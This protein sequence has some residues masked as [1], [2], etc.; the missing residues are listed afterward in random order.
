VRE[1]ALRL[2]I[3]AGVNAYER[4]DRAAAAG[5]YRQGL[6]HAEAFLKAGETATGVREQALRLY[7]GAG[8]NAFH[9]G[10]I[11]GARRHE[12]FCQM[13]YWISNFTGEALSPP[14]HHHTLHTL[15]DTAIPPLWTSVIHAWLLNCHGSQVDHLANHELDTL[16]RTAEAALLLDQAE[17]NHRFRELFDGLRGFQE[18]TQTALDAHTAALHAAQQSLLDALQL[19]QLS[20]PATPNAEDCAAI[21]NALDRRPWWK[22]LLKSHYRRAWQALRYYRTQLA[23]PP[24][25]TNPQWRQIERGQRAL[26]D[27]LVERLRAAGRLPATL[28]DHTQ[29]ALAV[30]LAGQPDSPAATVARWR[31]QPPWGDPATLTATLDCTGWREWLPEPGDTPQLAVYAWTTRQP[32]QRRL[33]IE[34]K[35]LN[36]LDHKL[37][38]I[39]IAFRDHG[40]PEPLPTWLAAAWQ[41]AQPA[42]EAV[43]RLLQALAQH[44]QTDAP[45][46]LKAALQN[47]AAAAAPFAD[48]ALAAVVLGDVEAVLGQA[49]R[50]WLDR[51]L[52]LDQDDLAETLQ[53]LKQRFAHVLNADPGPPEATAL[54]QRL[55]DWSQAAL[56]RELAVPNPDPD[57]LW[58]HL[59]RGRIALTGLA[60]N[61]PDDEWK[62]TTAKELN[63][64]IRAHL[65]AD[66]RPGAAWPPLA[67]WLQRTAAA[68]PTAPDAAACQRRLKPAE[69]LAQLFFDPNS[70]QLQALWLTP[71]APLTRRAFPATAQADHWRGDAGIL[72]RWARWAEGGE[73]ETGFPDVFATFAASAPTRAL[74]ATLHSWAAETGCRHLVLLL[75]AELAQL[76]WEALDAFD[77]ERLTLE[78]PVH[79]AGWRGNDHP[80]PVTDPQAHIAW[81]ANI[82]YGP[83]EAAA[84]S[85]YWRSPAPQ[86]DDEA[87]AFD[88]MAGLHTRAHGHLTLHGRYDPLDP[89]AS[90]L[91][92]S[93]TERI[94]AWTL[95]ALNP[96]GHIALSA[97]QAGLHGRPAHERRWLGSVG[98]GPALLAAGARRVIAPLW[99]C[100][101]VATWLFHELLYEAAA[102][103]PGA[104]WPRL[105]AWT[106]ERLRV[107][108]LAD[109]EARLRQRRGKSY[110]AADFI[111]W[112][113]QDPP[114]ANPVHWA[115]FVLLGEGDPWPASAS[116]TDARSREFGSAPLEETA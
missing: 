91:T 87:H 50:G 8:C 18:A 51:H 36:D 72:E 96:R 58:V 110:R 100:N 49:V 99:R 10:L 114:F 1:Q 39:L 80:P 63:A 77:P 12:M 62:T 86:A 31:T 65:D 69:A 4:G 33:R 67:V 28:K 55:H 108:P 113:E 53:R 44:A 81:G 76:P 74:V 92:V 21:Q 88:I 59:E 24:R 32:H 47:T 71:R 41:Q 16:L 45:P 79:L 104:S 82:G 30:L 13:L 9:C 66:P 78:R 106:R 115:G 102:A 25:L 60:V 48:A 70:G 97:C 17:Q 23:T 34:E 107:L 20:A 42:A 103:Q 7:N 29:V 61:A 26:A 101:Q 98:L 38:T 89:R 116:T 19:L 40:D 22:R 90:H 6:D 15:S 93:A 2:Y 84:A 94:P 85:A 73:L 27:W 105:L 5:F 111:E 52:L 83:E 35:Q 64:A 46:D 112:Q 14:I 43:G 57:A 11:H 95:A 68:L 54:Q 109:I 56:G 75:P 37:Q 3:N